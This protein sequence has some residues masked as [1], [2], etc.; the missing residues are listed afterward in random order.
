MERKRVQ[1]LEPGDVFSLHPLSECWTFLSKGAVPEWATTLVHVRSK[2][3]GEERLESY[4]IGTWV[5]VHPPVREFLVKYLDWATPGGPVVDA[6]V[7]LPKL[8]GF[9]KGLGRGCLLDVT[10]VESKNPL[11]G[12]TKEESND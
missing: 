2:T 7:E 8:R 5:C 10:E 3:T 6:R 12:E 9:V 1:D 4:L 11:P